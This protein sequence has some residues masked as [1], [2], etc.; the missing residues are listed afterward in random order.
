MIGEAFLKAPNPNS[1][2]EIMGVNSAA[3]EESIMSYPGRSVLD[4][5]LSEV[6]ASTE[7]IHHDRSQQRA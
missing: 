4:G 7:E 3:A 6:R 2:S 5:Q 1:Q